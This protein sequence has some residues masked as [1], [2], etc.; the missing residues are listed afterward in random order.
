FSAQIVGGSSTQAHFLYRAATGQIETVAAVGDPSPRGDV[1]AVLG[2]ATLGEQGDIVFGAW[3]SDS[4]IDGLEAYVLRW[5]DG[6]L[7][8]LL[9]PG[10]TVPGGQVVGRVGGSFVTF[11]DGSKALLLP[12]PSLTEDGRVVVSAQV[13]NAFLVLEIDGQQRRFITQPGEA[14]PGGGTFS[15]SNEAISRGGR[16]AFTS[17]SI[18][19]GAPGDWGAAWAPGQ[20]IDGHPVDSITTFLGNRPSLDEAGQI[21]VVFGFQGS[22]GVFETRLARWNEDDGLFSLAA[23]G[24][25][26]PGGG[27]FLQFFNFSGVN[28]RGDAVIDTLIRRPG[29][30]LVDAL[31]LLDNCAAGRIFTDGFESGATDAWSIAVP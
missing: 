1:L 26:A 7:E 10:D 31:F 17:N 28:A 9:G 16:Y 18:T 21:T 14:D 12:S 27:V 30:A 20:T 25:P 8:R 22:P 2:P 23:D 3:D 4:V 15:V 5:R 19:V 13:G 29:G 24:D 11:A 6:A